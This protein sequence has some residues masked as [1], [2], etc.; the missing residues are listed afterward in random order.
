M[1]AGTSGATSKE[2][3]FTSVKN[4]SHHHGATPGSDAGVGGCGTAKG[5]QQE[6]PVRS[7]RVMPRDDG[8][9]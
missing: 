4:A 1:L 3:G 9:E 5:A 6:A 8:R 7:A 2:V